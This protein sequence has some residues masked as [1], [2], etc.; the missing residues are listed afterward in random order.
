MTDL[1]PLIANLPTIP[2]SVASFQSGSVTI[3][4][5]VGAQVTTNITL[6]TAVNIAKSLISIDYG[7][8]TAAVASS[9]TRASLTSTT[10]LQLIT[11]A[12]IGGVADSMTLNWQVLTWN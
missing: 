10:N 9:P 11:D 3:T 4:P 1:T 2:G 7:S 6:G 12:Q 8:T 5:A